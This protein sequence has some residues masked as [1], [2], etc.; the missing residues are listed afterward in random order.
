MAATTADLTRLDAILKDRELQDGIVDTLNKATPF[1]ER[2]TQELP[3]SGRKGIYPV[4]FGANEGIYARPEKGTFGDSQVDEPDLAEVQAKYLYAL[5]DITGPAMAMTGDSEGS[6]EEAL[7]L[8]LKNTIDGFKLDMARQVLGQGDG[9]IALIQSVTDTDTI[10]V[11]SAFGLTTYKEDR[12]VRNL[13]RANMPFDVIDAGDGTTKHG[14]NQAVSTVTHS[15]T[16]TTIDFASTDGSLTSAAD[17]DYVTR[18][19]NRNHE[20]EGFFAAVDTAGSYHGITRS[21]KPAWQGTLVDAADG[22]STA[23]PLDPDVLRDTLD[24]IMEQTGKEP[25]FITC[26]YKQRRNIYNLLAPQIRYA[27][28][29]LPGGLREDTLTFDDLPVVVERFFPAEHIGVV[30]TEFWYHTINT[31]TEWIQGLNGT[32]L[33]FDGNS[34]QFTAVLRTY[35]NLACL[36]PATNG[37]IYGLQE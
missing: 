25:D 30:N 18:A 9:T 14:D 31:D 17:G 12:P 8:T 27:P 20:I 7:A 4:Q 35:R 10:V 6:F 3:I 2:I 37:L 26:N 28:M 19:G 34:D 23:V 5:F 33:H 21:G 15:G 11:D 32:V 22:G 36:W 24:L 16:G 1:M 13:I 29:M